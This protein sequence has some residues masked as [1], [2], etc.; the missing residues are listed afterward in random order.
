M[1]N[2]KKVF[3]KKIL[4]SWSWRYIVIYKSRYFNGVDISLQWN[5]SCKRIFQTYVCGESTCKTKEEDL[6]TREEVLQGDLD[7]IEE[8]ISAVYCEDCQNKSE[9]VEKIETYAF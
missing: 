9:I 2:N 8:E 7:K 5:C 1:V 6:N 3:S 4:L